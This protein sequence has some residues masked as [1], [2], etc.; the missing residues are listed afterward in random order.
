ME[1]GVS[2]FSSAAAEAKRPLPYWIYDMDVMA[3]RTAWSF[4]LRQ[5]VSGKAKV[6]DSVM[7]AL[8]TVDP[9]LCL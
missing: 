2:Q 4:T 9:Y 8:E 3:A 6:I 5:L 1:M 7:H